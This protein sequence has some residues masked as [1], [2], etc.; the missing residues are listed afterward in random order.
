VGRTFLFA[1]LH[2]VDLPVCSTSSEGRTVSPTLDAFLRSWPFEP[3]L[4]VVLLLS[5]W[6]YWRGWR[7]LRGRLKTPPPIPLPETERGS[8]VVFLPLSASGRGSGGGVAGH[9]LNRR[10]PERWH[11]GRLGAFLGGLAA[12]FLALGSPIE[13]FASL[14]LQVHM[15]QHLLLSMVAPPLIWLGAPLFPLLR[16]LPAPIRVYWAGPLFR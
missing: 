8:R 12:V 14:L 7:V 1:L 15:V 11:S 2:G 6:V 3:W 10:A 4:L 16:G 9:P 13:P 5:A